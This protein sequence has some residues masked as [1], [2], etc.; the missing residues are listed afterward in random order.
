LIN[1]IGDIIEQELGIKKRIHK[2]QNSIKEDK[3][4]RVLMFGGNKQVLK[5][6]NWLYDGATIY[7]QRKYNK[8]CELYSINNSLIA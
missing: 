8:Y 4:T 7:L 1:C 5:F 6:L 2:A 3:N